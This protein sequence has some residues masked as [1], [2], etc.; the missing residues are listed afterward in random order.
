MDLRQRGKTITLLASMIW[1][2]FFSLWSYG[3]WL[4]SLFPLESNRIYVSIAALFLAGTIICYLILNKLVIPGFKQLSRADRKWVLGSSIFLGLFLYISAFNVNVVN[5]KTIYF[6]L[7]EQ[8]LE[9]QASQSQYSLAQDIKLQ[10]MSTSVGDISFNQMVSKGWSRVNQDGIHKML[11]L[12]EYQGNLVSWRGRTGAIATLIFATS[13][14]GGSVEVSWNGVKQIIDLNSTETGVIEV[15]QDFPV[16]V[17]AGWIPL[18]IF[19]LLNIPIA[20]LII[21]LLAINSKTMSRPIPARPYDWLKYA[22]PMAAVWSFYLLVFYPGFMSIDSLDQ[23]R[24]ML[25]GQYVDWH[26]PIHTLTNWLITRIWFSPAAISIVQIFALSSVLGWGVAVIR[27]AGAPLWVAW[28]TT[29]LLAGSPVNGVMVITLWKD[30]AFSIA[31][32]ALTIQVFEIV[33][34]RGNWLER[35]NHWVAFG[36]VLALTALYRQNGILVSVGSGLA[37]LAVYRPHWRKGLLSLILFLGLWGIVKEGLYRA[38]NVAPNQ[39]AQYQKVFLNVVA[40]QQ[41]A[42]TPFLQGEK[43]VLKSIFPNGRIPYNCKHN[44]EL[45]QT[46]YTQPIIRHTDSIIL[47]ALRLIYTSPLVTIR[48]VACNGAFVYRM[49]GDFDYYE[50]AY[51]KIKPNEFGLEQKSLLPKIKPLLLKFSQDAIDQSGNMNWIFWRSPFWMFLFVS[52]IGCACIKRKSGRDFLVITPALLV[53]LPLILISPLPIFRYVYP[54]V[55]C[56]M[57]LS[58]YYWSAAA[59]REDM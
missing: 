26:P 3:F 41:N 15:Q 19:L 25:T 55:L 31:V 57:L 17:L 33:R 42:G 46:G 47:M 13:P 52:G 56:G 16:P 4:P 14:T 21:F 37:I 51:L 27:R 45:D 6:L 38:L 43:T 8:T 22:L 29:I 36:A 53:V 32:T 28:A 7:P 58:G 34:S 48:H 35:R 59:S 39:N 24:Q 12:N 5:H 54:M 20:L 30:I 18:A 1:A 50:T 2:F 49:F 40:A 23:W 11:V 10:G 44:L 9:I